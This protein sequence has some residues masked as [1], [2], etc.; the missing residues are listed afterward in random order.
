MNTLATSSTD[1]PTY[2]RNI[3]VSAVERVERRVHEQ[4]GVGVLLA[5]HVREVHVARTARAARRTSSTSGRRCGCFT[6]HAPSHLLEHEHRVAAHLDPPRPG[7]HAPPRAP[8]SA[9]GTRP[10][11]WWSARCTR[12]PRRA[13]P[14]AS[15]DGSS[16][17]APIAA[18]PGLPRDPPS[19]EIISRRYGVVDSARRAARDR[20]ASRD[21]RQRH[22]MRHVRIAPQ[23]SQ[24]ATVPGGA[25]RMR[26][27]RW[28]GS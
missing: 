24:W 6:F 28:P 20:T 18:G 19:K 3:G 23:L 4:V 13:A 7:T 17:T 22:G 26:R 1:R 27:P 14:A 9:R 25:L 16:T 10:R 12:S 15:V 5:R 8:R 21:G 11:C 2:Q